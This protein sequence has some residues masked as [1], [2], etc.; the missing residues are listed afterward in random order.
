M[1]GKNHP[2]NTS[3]TGNDKH[4]FIGSIINKINIYLPYS[5]SAIGLTETAIIANDITVNN[6]R[7]IVEFGSGISTFIFAKVIQLN[8]LDATIYTVDENKDWLEL[9]AK[10]CERE[11]LTAVKFIHAPVAVQAK[12]K[13]EL[14]YDIDAVENA[15][16]ARKIDT[17][18]IDG[19]AAYIKG[20]ERIRRHALYFLD[21][22]NTDASLFFDDIGRDGEREAF[23]GLKASHKELKYF[24][25][26]AMGIAMKGNYYNIF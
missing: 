23:E 5:Q 25:E 11:G 4:Y 10:L 16:G 24:M 13:N 8:K 17:L 15:I 12:A 21:H 22:L 6:R 7:T 9:M 1:V 19:P 3:G 2:G 20:R 26:N 18:I 14:Y